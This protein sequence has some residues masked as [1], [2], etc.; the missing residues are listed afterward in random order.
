MWIYSVGKNKNIYINSTDKVIKNIPPRLVE[1]I[2]P[3][4]DRN[5]VLL[6]N[7]TEGIINTRH[8]PLSSLAI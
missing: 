7:Q 8:E 3:T 5:A 4:L 2:K 1:S 6:Q